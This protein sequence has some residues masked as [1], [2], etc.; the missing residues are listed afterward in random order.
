MMI[1]I[2]SITWALLCM[3]N[4]AIAQ[5][6]EDTSSYDYRKAHGK[7]AV[8]PQTA[9][10]GNYPALV[11]RK[12]QLQSSSSAPKARTLMVAPIGGETL[13]CGSTIADPATDTS[14]H[15]LARD[16]DSES[17]FVKLPFTFTLFGDNYRTAYIGTNGTIAFNGPF[18]SF[19]AEGFPYKGA[20]II[21]AFWADIDTTDPG[22]GLVYY[23]VDSVNHRLTVIWYRV[24][25]FSRHYDKVNTFK[26]VITDGADPYIGVGYNVGLLYGDMQWTTGDYEYRD[27]GG[28]GGF[29]DSPPATVGFNKG[30]GDNDCFFV[31]IGR[32]SKSGKEFLGSRTNS[33]VDYL[34]GWCNAF[35]VSKIENVTSSIT[36]ERFY[37]STIFTSHIVNNQSCDLAYN[38]NF[39]DGTTSIEPDPIHEFKRDG[40][41]NVTLTVT[42]TCGR[43]DAKT[44]TSQTQVVVKSDEGQLVQTDID[45]TTE[46]H[47][48]VLSTQA[49]TFSDTWPM[50]S[51]TGNFPTNN[52]YLNGTSGVWRND[53]SYAYKTDRKLSDPVDIS[54][55]GTFDAEDFN[56]TYASLNAIPGW[57][58]ANAITQYSTHSFELENKDVL[59]VYSAALYDYG[60]QLATATG[61]NMKN[62]EMA[63]TGFE[64]LDDG[65]SGN[66]VVSDKILPAYYTYNVRSANKNVAVVEAPAASFDGVRK[67]D[68]FG[69]GVVGIGRSQIPGISRYVADNE[70]ICSLQ[71]PDNPAWTIV[72]FRRSFYPGSW[73]GTMVVHNAVVQGVNPDIDNTFA[74]TGGKSLRI[75]GQS[76]TFPQSLIHLDSGKTYVLN[77]WVSV[78]NPHAT[79]PLLARDLG[80]DVVLKRTDG[81][82]STAYIVPEGPVVAGWQQVR[83]TIN[84]N[85]NDTKLELVFKPGST[86]TAWYDDL[87]IH[88]EKGNMKSFVYNLNDY[89]LRAV[90][91]EEN[92]ATLYYYDEEGNLYLT[93]QE[94]AKGIKT[95]SENVSYIKERKK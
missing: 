49:S 15:K 26:L 24:G 16:D 17:V 42:Y 38:W 72:V 21:A 19:T 33:G 32:F 57:I 3:A 10:K 12:Q 2:Y 86:G 25:Y 56:W 77:A 29:G 66:L 40:T 44:T 67:A 55:D 63:F 31:Q 27:V 13:L 79:V 20:A 14:F 90:L 43:C 83:G 69:R 34:D 22:S 11:T 62:T 23:K 94:T 48:E 35:D 28:S 46:T 18:T 80:I 71:H 59:G 65:V 1:R 91:D 58:Q 8:P 54:K 50:L 7:F 61:S 81:T 53:G 78:K 84:C 5:V 39:G 51:A 60:G 75:G 73:K 4:L 68:L 9:Y 47:A 52:G 95:L 30:V 92:F 64:Y 93:K 45:V 85:Y 6:D 36:Y 82:T 88:P 41:Y 76:K 37:C 70:V 87:R 74:H 89:R